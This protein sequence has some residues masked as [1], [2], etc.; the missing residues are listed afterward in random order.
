M[1]VA[2]SLPART[3]N[4]VNDYA[5]I[6]NP[7]VRT[8]LEQ[9]LAAFQ[10]TD[11]TQ[12]VVAT[13][14]T[15]DGGSIEDVSIRLAEQWQIGQKGKDNGVLLIVVSEDRVARIEVGYGLEDK[16]TDAVSSQI[17]SNDMAPYFRQQQYS[18]GIVAGVQAIQ[19]VVRGTYTAAT[20]KSAR[21]SQNG[22]PWLLLFP[23]LF[24]IL[25]LRRRRYIGYNS[26]GLFTG[27]L[28]SHLLGGGGKR[29]GGFGGGGGFG[30]FSGGGGGFGGG[31]A[32][33][34]W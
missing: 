24:V 27:L 11:S 26:S 20:K 18:Q 1:S 30:G 31:G 17:I 28:L 15:L 5:H 25:T 9:E 8:Q 13:F 33:G 34:K 6:L 3:N 16:L 21:T 14:A 32:S 4:Y 2:Q 12:I 7:A 22:S 23:L 19:N 29:R 10:N